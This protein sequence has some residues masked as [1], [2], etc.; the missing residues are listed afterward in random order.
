MPFNLVVVCPF[1]DRFAGEL[2]S[3]VGNYTGGFP[4]DPDQRIQLPG[5]PGPGDAGAGDQA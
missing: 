3:V 5:D 1:Q 2:R 4:I